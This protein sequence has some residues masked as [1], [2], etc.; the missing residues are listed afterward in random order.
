MLIKSG[1]G[2]LF[3]KVLGTLLMFFLTVMLA[4]VLGVEGFG[5]YSLVLSAVMLLSIPVQ[6][7]IPTLA[8]R[9]VSKAVAGSKG[10]FVQ[11]IIRWGNR[12]I[13]LYSLVV[14][15]GVSAVVFFSKDV[16]GD[17]RFSVFVVGLISL[18]LLSLMLFRSAVLRGLGAVVVGV[19][20]DGFLRPAANVVLLFVLY[21]FCSVITLGPIHA[22]ATYVLSVVL[23][24]LF[25]VFMHSR[26]S[27]SY[28]LSEHCKV[29]QEWRS[30]LYSLTVVGG[31]QILFGYMDTLILGWLR[32]DRD[33]GLYRVAVQ[34]SLL[35]S[36]SLTVL[37]QMLQPHFARLYAQNEGEALQLL[38]AKSSIMIF[39]MAIVSAIIFLVGGEWLIVFIFGEEYRFS[40]AALQILVV[41]QLA[42]AMFGS[43][44]ALLNMTGHEKDSM[45]GMVVAVIVNAVLNLALIPVW[46]G[47]GAAIA[48]AVSFV[49]WNFVLRVYVKKQLSL[50][51][52]GLIYYLKKNF[53]RSG[54]LQ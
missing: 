13:F 31:A 40:F 12:L 33:V 37:N 42:N 48:S 36:F 41:G 52:S 47:V 8:V 18:P 54:R 22:L 38:V 43:V 23:A 32:D 30:A 44:G 45:K 34:L 29:P 15:G 16:L 51:S 46:G 28:S 9:E 17:P 50:E 14:I 27:K 1:L 53:F 39:S 10:E 7:G 21:K 5:L 35:V 26:I 20:P 19:A 25:V 49:V 11:T 6:A 3:V 24:L 2:V 4:R